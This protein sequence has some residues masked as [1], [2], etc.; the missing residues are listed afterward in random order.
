VG[1]GLPV[2]DPWQGGPGGAPFALAAAFGAVTATPRRPQITQIGRGAI[3]RMRDDLPAPVSPQL[4]AAELL[5]RLARSD[6]EAERLHVAGQWLQARTAVEA[7]REILAAADQAPPSLRFLAVGLA[8]SLGDDALAVWRE[9][10]Q[11]P[12]IG[13]HAR[14]VLASY[15]RGQDMSEPDRRWLAADQAATALADAGPDKALTCVHETMPGAD[16]DSRLAAIR[17]SG[18]PDAE[19]LARTLAAFAASGAPRRV[20]QVIQLKITLAGCR[21]PIWR[22][23][24]VPAIGT[25]GS[26]HQ[27]IQV[28]YGWDGDHLH[29]FTAGD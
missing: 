5:A 20:D 10:S 27:V 23:V 22:R 14:G 4:P 2:F 29:A 25:L 12:R 9:M 17:P 19:T 11:A 26:L 21:P 1:C 16:L 28:L 13:P 24:L 15:G 3:A 8:E 18:H 7:A 6:K